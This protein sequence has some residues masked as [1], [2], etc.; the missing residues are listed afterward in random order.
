LFT[1]DKI[2]VYLWQIGLKLY[3]NDQFWFIFAFFDYE[4]DELYN[5]LGQTSDM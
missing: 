5:Y 2:D 3:K 1:L 4:C